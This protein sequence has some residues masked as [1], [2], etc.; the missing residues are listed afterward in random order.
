VEFIG[1]NNT[2]PSR[3]ILGKPEVFITAQGESLVGI[4]VSWTV[5]FEYIRYLVQNLDFVSLPFFYFLF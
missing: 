1:T 4:V 2:N 3:N 5:I